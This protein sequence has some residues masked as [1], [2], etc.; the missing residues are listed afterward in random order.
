MCVQVSGREC[1]CG[2][3]SSAFPDCLG[4]L[5]EAAAQEQEQWTQ[6]AAAAAYDSACAAGV[7][8]SA[9]YRPPS[10][11]VCPCGYSV[12]GDGL[13]AAEARRGEAPEQCDDRCLLIR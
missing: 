12:C 3:T 2:Q 5:Y 6:H 13:V 7:P 8:S 1:A 4:T 9:L 11:K 10:G